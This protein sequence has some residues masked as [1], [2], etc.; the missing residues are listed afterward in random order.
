MVAQDEEKSAHPFETLANLAS[1]WGLDVYSDEFAAE[2][3][4]RQIWPCLRD[5]F[6]YPKVKDLPYIDL[7]LFENPN[8][9]CIYFVGN[10]LGLQP[11][12]ARDYIGVELDKWAKM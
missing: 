6:H 11:K 1:E 9:E 3:D 5:K 4:K 2:L 8:D 12:S 10:S 7:D